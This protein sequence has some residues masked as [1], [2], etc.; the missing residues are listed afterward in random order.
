[1]RVYDASAG[2]AV[3]QS[4]Q[5][6]PALKRRLEAASENL[7]DWQLLAG[8][9]A[10]QDDWEEA[11]LDAQR[12]LALHRDKRWLALGAWVAGPYPEDFQASYPPERVFPTGDAAPR[13]GTLLSWESVPLR[14]NGF[15]NF[16][17][18]FGQAEHISAYALVRVYS[19]TEQPVALMLGSDDRLRLWLNGKLIHENQESRRAVADADAVPARL[20]A[21]WNTLLARVINL[22][23]DHALYL[24]LSDAPD[25]L[26]RAQRTAAER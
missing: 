10:R 13:R 15:I 24:R 8:I 7:A 3:A 5:Y 20:D 26:L 14:S 12:C 21:G 9:H 18:L 17:S 16:G 2:Y 6:L 23:G 11:E 1:M 22:A 19:L 4:P 25:D